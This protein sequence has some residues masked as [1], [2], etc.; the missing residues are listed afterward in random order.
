MHVPE[1]KSR[2]SCHPFVSSDLDGLKEMEW[3]LSQD[4]GDPNTPWGRGNGVVSL[5]FLKSGSIQYVDL[6]GSQKKRAR[7]LA[8]WSGTV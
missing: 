2:N 3:H 1:V 8:T 7:P 4:N 6:I 5:N